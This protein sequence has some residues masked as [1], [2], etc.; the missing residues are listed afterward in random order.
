MPHRSVARGLA[1]LAVLAFGSARAAAQEVTA[2]DLVIQHPW[3]RATPG[4]AQTAGGYVTILNRGTASDRLVGGSFEAASGFEL[5]DMSM[6]AGVMRMRA[7]GPL[8]IPAHG[9]LTLT[10]VGRHAMLT[11]LK[12]GLKKGEQVRGTLVFEHAGTVPV[13]F[14]VEGIGAREP[15]GGAKPS[16]KAMPGMHMD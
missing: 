6:D 13:Q 4:G 11:G 5:H 2:G 7:T 16:E 3:S 15:G 1:L 12:H 10:P 14:D 8:T 9:S